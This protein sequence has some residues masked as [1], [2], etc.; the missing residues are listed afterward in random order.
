MPYRA[1]ARSI[2]FVVLLGLVLTVSSPASATTIQGTLELVGTIMPGSSTPLILPFGLMEISV[3]EPFQGQAQFSVAF[4]GGGTP[5]PAELPASLL[6]FDLTI[7]NTHWDANMPHSDV[8][9]LVQGDSLLG[10]EVFLT[11]TTP[12][13]DLSFF[14]PSS[15]GTWEAHDWD[16]ITDHGTIRGTYQ[17]NA[18]VVPEPTTM[19]LLGSG[20][21]GLWGFRKKFRK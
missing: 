15:P 21:A 20:L 11:D 1:F 6:A 18:T 17:V 12:H 14:L 16:G 2:R 9:V 13:P 7:G 3:T 19:L 5:D 8:E 10:L 4:V